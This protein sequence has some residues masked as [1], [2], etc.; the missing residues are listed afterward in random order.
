M[1]SLAVPESHGIR[2]PD[3]GLDTKFPEYILKVLADRVG[4]EREDGRDFRIALSF[5]QPMKNLVLPGGQAGE[6][7]IL[8][9]RWGD[10]NR[11][12]YGQPSQNSV[13][14]V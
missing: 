6:Q 2:C 14:G 8:P 1:C 4:A 5:A 9:R 7:G 13:E 11:K 3:T 12:K 10:G